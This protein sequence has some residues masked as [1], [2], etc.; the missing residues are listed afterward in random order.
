MQDP[1]KIRNMVKYKI[2]S[3]K[4]LEEVIQTNPIVQAFVF[5]NHDVTLL[6]SRNIFYMNQLWILSYRYN[7]L[8]HLKTTYQDYKLKTFLYKKRYLLTVHIL[9][10]KIQIE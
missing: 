5:Y 9:F 3:L 6:K 2:Y 10:P 1:S 4:V 8:Y 7:S